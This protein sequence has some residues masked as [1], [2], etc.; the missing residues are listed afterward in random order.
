MSATDWVCAQVVSKAGM[1]RRG[2]WLLAA[3]GEGVS[4]VARNVD[5]GF[6]A[7]FLPW[8]SSERAGFEERDRNEAFQITQE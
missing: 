4:I 3:T 1:L 6:L 7:S 5:L 8:I 2:L